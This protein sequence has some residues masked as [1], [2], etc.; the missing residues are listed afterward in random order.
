AF[1][2]SQPQVEGNRSF[3]FIISSDPAA[4]VADAAAG[5]VIPLSAHDI[6]TSPSGALPRHVRCDREATAPWSIFSRRTSHEPKKA[7][8]SVTG[9][10][11]NPLPL[12][13]PAT[14][15]DY[16]QAEERSESPST[17]APSSEVSGAAR[18][19]LRDGKDRPKATPAPRGLAQN[20]RNSRPRSGSNKVKRGGSRENLLSLTADVGRRPRSGSCNKVKRCGSRENFS[21]SVT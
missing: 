4:S 2:Q 14:L 3:N 5:A 10:R 9:R 8:I 16:C 1:L 20:R 15:E 13:A 21:A 12:R 11:M 7:K 6:H 17:A 19:G 18:D